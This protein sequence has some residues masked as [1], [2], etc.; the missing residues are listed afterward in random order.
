MESQ[1]I[2]MQVGWQDSQSTFYIELACPNELKGCSSGNIIKHGHDTS[3][4]GDPQHYECKEC[5]RHFYPHTSG[6]FFQLKNSINERLFSV[7]RDGKIDTKLL[8][9]IL[10]SSPATISKIMRYIVEN[11]ANHPKTEIFWKTPK[12]AQAIFIDETWINIS[13]RTWYLIVLLNE[14]GNVLVFELVKH[15]TSEKIIELIQRA[16]SR[17]NKTIEILVTDDFSTYKGVATGL[18][19]DL[20]HVR[21]IHQPPYG[22]IVVDKIE[23]KEKEIVTTHLAT[24]NDI[25]LET[26]T[27]II[28]V[29]KSVKTIHDTG[30]R[31]RKKGGKNRPKA[32]IIHEKR[33]KKKNKDATKRGPKNPFKHGET[34][35]Y[36]F[37]KKKGLFHPK[38][39]SDENVVECLQELCSVFQNKHITTNPV[40]NIFSVLK[41][42]IDFR[43]KRSLEYW[44]LLIRYF[45]T[46]REFPSILKEILEEVEF[47]PQ[48]HHKSS[49]KILI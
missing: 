8:G 43:G 27:F 17:L 44:Q 36:H 31:G 13:K 40:E 49:V 48:I 32:V 25:F 39:G 21:H 35:V 2:P 45:F 1:L 30:K 6:F 5:H 29:S 7:L 3:V 20:I 22:R 42:L 10:G 11:V 23:I 24:T 9:E 34:H 18:K 41:K 26:G 14:K 19:R 37:D 12:T 4:K 16:E 15:R 38:Y 46:I 33:Q 28:Q 47:S